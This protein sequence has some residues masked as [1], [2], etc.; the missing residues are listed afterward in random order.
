MTAFDRIPNKMPLV[1]DDPTP[2]PWPDFAPDAEISAFYHLFDR[3]EGWLGNAWFMIWDRALTRH[4]VPIHA[5][6]WPADTRS[7]G[8]NGGGT[9]FGL[10]LERGE[11]VYLSAPDIGEVEDIRVFET[12]D[13]LIDHIAQADMM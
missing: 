1:P 7:F 8:S 9:M 13:G 12:W 2:H 6:L 4:Q 3:A 11:A 10:R 5:E